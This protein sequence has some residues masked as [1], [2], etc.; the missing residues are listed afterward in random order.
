MELSGEFPVRTFRG[1][2]GETALRNHGTQRSSFYSWKM[3]LSNPSN[4]TKNF[5]SN[6][7]LFHKFHLRFPSHGHRWLNAKIR[8]D[9]GLL[10][11]D[12]YAHKCC[13]TADIK[14]KVRHYKY[15]KPSDLYRVFPNLLLSDFPLFLIQF[16][17]SIFC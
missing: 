1:V 7:R 16:F 10:L 9:T 5:V 6:V 3:Q 8:L 13:K 2:S 15:K 11:S 4:R 14:S 17:V 12:P